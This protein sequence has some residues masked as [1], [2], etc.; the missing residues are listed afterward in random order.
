MVEYGAPGTLGKGALLFVERDFFL[1]EGRITRFP[2]VGT[3]RQ[4]RPEVVVPVHQLAA[5][6][7][8]IALA[9]LHGGRVELVHGGAVG[10]LNA[11][12]LAQEFLAFLRRGQQHPHDV[13]RAV[14]EPDAPRAHPELVQGKVA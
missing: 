10:P 8:G 12:E 1:E 14:P 2:D 11:E 3:D 5:F 9:G 7:R 4:Y 6:F 13:L